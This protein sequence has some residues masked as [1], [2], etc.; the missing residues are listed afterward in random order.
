M[1]PLFPYP[2]TTPPKENGRY[3][4]N[5]GYLFYQSEGEPIPFWTESAIA[6]VKEQRY[7]KY[8]MSESMPPELAKVLEEVKKELDYTE[9]DGRIEMSMEKS[10]IQTI[11]KYL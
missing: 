8:Y 4:T 5:L 10:Q 7:P 11:L 3:I 2:V 6:G 9:Y 1:K